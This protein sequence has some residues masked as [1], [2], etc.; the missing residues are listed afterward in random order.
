MGL[1]KLRDGVEGE[2]LDLAQL[3]DRQFEVGALRL[4]LLDPPLAQERIAAQ[5]A[6]TLKAADHEATA[7]LAA[8]LRLFLQLQA[9]GLQQGGIGQGA[10]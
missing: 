7:Q 4:Q 10:E 1:G 8:L 2:L 9:G 5:I 3:F 6:A